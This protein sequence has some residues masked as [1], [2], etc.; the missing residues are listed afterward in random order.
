[1]SDPRLDELKAHV[2]QGLGWTEIGGRMGLHESSVRRLAKRYGVRRGYQTPTPVDEPTEIPVI[3][4]DYSHEDRHFVY[5][6][7]D[8]HLG[9][10]THNSSVWTDWLDYLYGRPETSLLGTGD[11]LNSGIVGSKSEVYDETSTVGQAKRTL[12]RQL[13]ALASEGRVDGL[14]P[15]N[16]EDRIYRAVGDCPILDVCDSLEVPYVEAAALFVYRVGDVEYTLYLRHGTGNGQS[17]VT[18]SK[19]SLV[20]DA[21]IYVTGHTHRQALTADDYFKREGDRVVRAKRYYISSGSFLG[22]EKYAAQR[23]YPPSTIGAPRI[24]LDGTRHDVSVSL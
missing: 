5:P 1:M 23:G 10:R 20:I 9:A 13:K 18:L 15:G 4:R 21:D 16:H 8:V 22:Y 7:G 14:A 6:L 2:A 17:L 24:R 11:F 19:G 3:Y 12:R